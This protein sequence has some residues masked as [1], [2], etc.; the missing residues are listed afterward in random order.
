MFSKILGDLFFLYIE[1]SRPSELSSVSHLPTTAKEC[2]LNVF[3]PLEVPAALECKLCT[4]LSSAAKLSHMSSTAKI[5][6][7][8]KNRLSQTRVQSVVRNWD[9]NF[10]N[11][12]LVIYLGREVDLREHADMQYW[13]FSSRRGLFLTLQFPTSL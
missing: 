6:A 7:E 11:I 4:S 8:I 10:L 5:E 9:Y 3:W 2:I 1:L 12:A 13:C